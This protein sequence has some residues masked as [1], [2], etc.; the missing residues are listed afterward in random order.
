MSKLLEIVGYDG[1]TTGHRL[2]VNDMSYVHDEL[3]SAVAY[4]ATTL[5]K[6]TAYYN[7]VANNSHILFQSE[8]MNYL[9]TNAKFSD[10]LLRFPEGK[11]TKGA[12]PLTIFAGQTIEQSYDLSSVMQYGKLKLESLLLYM[13]GSYEINI[14]L[15]LDYQDAI[16]GENIFID[17][18][19]N[20]TADDD[21]KTVRLIDIASEIAASDLVLNSKSQDRLVIEIQAMT[22]CKILPQTFIKIQPTI[23]SITQEFD[24]PNEFEQSFSDGFSIARGL[25][26]DEINPIVS[27]VN[28]S[29]TFDVA[30]FIS[31]NADRL[32]LCFALRVAN[33]LLADKLTG[34]RLNIFTNTSRENTQMQIEELEIKFK[35][36]MKM[37]ASSLLFNIASAEVTPVELKGSV[38]YEMGSY[39]GSGHRVYDD[40]GAYPIS[41]IE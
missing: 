29:V 13:Q 11:L 23:N 20:L 36:H 6:V 7:R 26:L 32:A 34:K 38:G 33:R 1:I 22:D 9:G 35:Q 10:T 4:D 5:E 3:L 39:I 25:L 24:I 41:Y 17:K 30:E 12:E 37:I 21:Y 15:R 31:K 27:L 28:A 40:S 16:T 18:F 14:A 2:S 8:V 19:E